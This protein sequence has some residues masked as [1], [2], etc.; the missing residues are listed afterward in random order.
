MRPARLESDYCG[1]VGVVADSADE[2][3]CLNS[4]CKSRPKRIDGAGL[5]LSVPSGY[6]R[7]CVDVAAAVA[8]G[9]KN[10][11][12][13]SEASMASFQYVSMAA[14]NADLRAGGRGLGGHG[15]KLTSGLKPSSKWPSKRK[16]LKPRLDGSGAVGK[17]LGGVEL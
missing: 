17:G 7:S 4:S 14:S 2:Q 10:I 11:F 6:V 8:A 9:G 12:R 3:C 5:R 16:A 15:V 1:L 13:P